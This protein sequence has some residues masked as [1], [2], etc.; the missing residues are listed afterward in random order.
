MLCDQTDDTVD[1]SILDGIGL[2]IFNADSVRGYRN[3]FAS[4]KDGHPF[5]RLDDNEFLRSIGAAAFPILE[6]AD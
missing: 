4:L 5:V 6:I 2:E 3:T 1:M